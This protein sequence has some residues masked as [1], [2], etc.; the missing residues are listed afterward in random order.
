MTLMIKDRFV[1]QY[2]RAFRKNL[3]IISVQLED[4]LNISDAP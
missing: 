1:R 3:E 2:I 4:T